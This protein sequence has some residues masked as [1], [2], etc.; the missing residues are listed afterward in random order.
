MALSFDG[1]MSLSFDGAMS[2]DDQLAVEFEGLEARESES[3]VDSS[4]P[5]EEQWAI[6]DKEIEKH[7]SYRS[8]LFP[9][10]IA[11]YDIPPGRP[12]CCVLAYDD[13]RKDEVTP[14]ATDLVLP[15]YNKQNGTDYELVDC[16]DCVF[17]PHGKYILHCNFTAKP[18]E[19]PLKA[20]DFST[21]LFFADIQ[22]DP[23][24]NLVPAT[25]S[26]L[27]GGVNTKLGCE[28]CPDVIAH[29]TSG[30]DEGLIFLKLRLSPF[31]MRTAKNTC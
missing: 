13:A 16:L 9:H 12:N 14:V 15:A 7:M 30:P 3:I 5:W 1:A 25:Y 28:L 26:M 27:D 8:E 22:Q 23:K 11:P 19:A 18:K 29:P 31:F 6:L 21:K 2:L 20:G 17:T 24:G 4:L 10:W